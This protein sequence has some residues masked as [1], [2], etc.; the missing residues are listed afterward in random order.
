MRLLRAGAVA[1]L[2]AGAGCTFPGVRA[3]QAQDASIQTEAL[4][5]DATDAAAQA[6]PEEFSAAPEAAATVEAPPPAAAAVPVPVSLALTPAQTEGPYFKPGSPQRDSLL[7]P[8][9]AG[10]R[11]IITGRV[12]APDGTPV[13]NAKLDFWQADDRGAYDNAGYRLRGHVFTDSS[14]MYRLETIVPGVYP[15]RTRHIHVKVQAPGGPVLTTQLY[16]P[17]EPGNTRDGIYNPALLVT[18]QERAPDRIVAWFD[19]VVTT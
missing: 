13:A 7:E 12:L 6:P 11:L 2:L 4:A 19:F 10:T 9:M 5:Q 14:G 1:L 15:G 3:Q 17:D 16:L 18:V 8:R